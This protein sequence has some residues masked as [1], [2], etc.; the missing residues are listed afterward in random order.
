MG[1]FENSPRPERPPR[2][3]DPEADTLPAEEEVIAEDELARFE[4][5]V[6]MFGDSIVGSDLPDYVKAFVLE[7]VDIILR[8][9][10]DSD[11]SYAD[12]RES[13]TGEVRRIPLLETVWKIVRVASRP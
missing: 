1:S 7:Q 9:I 11:R 13:D 12:F 8:A 6:S 2:R 4:D 10:R 3:G 5:E